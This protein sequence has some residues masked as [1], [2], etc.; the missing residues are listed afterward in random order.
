MA[1]IILKPSL[2]SGESFTGKV[3]DVTETTCIFVLENG[4]KVK[5][6]FSPEVLESINEDHNSVM[7]GNIITITRNGEEF[8]IEEHDEWPKA[9]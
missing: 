7:G 1:G 3:D 2:K 6:P 4:K 8:E 9:K 5:I